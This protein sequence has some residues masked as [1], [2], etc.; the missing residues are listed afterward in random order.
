MTAVSRPDDGTSFEQ[1]LAALERSV[2]VDLIATYDLVTCATN[3]RLD[4]VLED[5]SKRNYDQIPVENDGRIVG[6]LERQQLAGKRPPKG[7]W[8]KD[9]MRRLDDSML[10][11]S[12]TGVLPYI[13]LASRARYHLVVKDHRVRGIVT[14]SDLLKLPVRVVLFTLITH[15]ESSMA[16]LI[17]RRF[18]CGCWQSYLKP[19]RLKK[20][21]DVQK[22]LEEQHAEND[23][24]LLL[25][26]SDKRDII[27]KGILPEDLRERFSA[28]LRELGKLRNSVM[29]ASNYM[30]SPG[31]L[32]SLVDSALEWIQ[33]LKEMR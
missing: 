5:Q 11:A 27:A 15:L 3:D 10:V 24:V 16:D 2:C 6:V 32:S 25:Q 19:Q 28:D 1:V 18:P 26:L 29:H 13:R 31:S 30:T 33:S 8:A 12:G 21:R 4:H 23:M 7:L 17:K 20:L 14:P 9:V 22:R